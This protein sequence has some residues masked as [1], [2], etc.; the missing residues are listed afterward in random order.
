MSTACYH[1]G[2]Q[3]P[4]GTILSAN[5]D[6]VDQPMCCLGCKSVAEFIVASGLNN[7]YRHRDEPEPGS[8]ITP[9]EGAWDRF[10]GAAIQSRYLNTDGPYA[11]VSIEIGGMYCRRLCVAA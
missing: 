6:G 8:A 3:V 1:C 5:L 7:F 11:E 2:D 9:V 10:D 4:Q